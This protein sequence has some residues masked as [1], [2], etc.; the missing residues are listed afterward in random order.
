MVRRECPIA[1]VAR[2]T[3]LLRVEM[4]VEDQMREVG[5][6]RDRDAPEPRRLAVERDA[7]RR[8]ALPRRAPAA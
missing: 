6:G 3:V 1:E 4:D 8:R 2:E 5:V 7:G